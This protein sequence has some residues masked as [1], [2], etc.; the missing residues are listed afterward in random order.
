MSRLLAI[1]TREYAAFFRVPLG[2][3]VAAIFLFVS[4]WVFSRGTLEPG[5]AASLREFFAAWWGLLVI[6][7]PAISMRLL[8]DE[9]RSG[10]IEG[11]L[12][13]PVNEVQIVTGKFLAAAAFLF[14]TL[15]PTVAYA[16]VLLWLSTPDVGPMLSGYLGVAL[17]GCLY[18]SVGTL[19]SCLT[20][21]QTLAFLG[22]LFGLL[23]F[24]IAAN[25]LALR[26]GAPWNTLLAG[27]S[28]NLRVADFA[29]GLIDTAHLGYFVSAIVLMLALA[30]L[31]IRFRRWR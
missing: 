16:G 11:L 14:T 29:R 10:T 18:L 6:V 2:W 8:S 3:I 27:L 21:S 12:T 20:A 15:A 13:S 25:Q 22:T 1:A 30:A 7:C 24:E 23:S 17:L 9:L 26:V 5:R 4:G 31:A 19:V 28:A